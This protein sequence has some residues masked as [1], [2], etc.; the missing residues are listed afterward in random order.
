MDDAKS[1]LKYM[2]RALLLARRG[3]GR[4]A[5]NP[6]VGAVIVKN[7]RIIGEGW[8]RKIGGLHAE[9][10]A[11]NSCTESPQGAT[12]YVNLEPCHHYGKTPP[13]TAAVLKAGIKRVFCAN[14]DPN[15]VAAGGLDYLAC[16]G[17][18]CHHGLLEKEA[19][20]LNRIFFFRQQEKTRPFIALKLALSL[21][22]CL[23]RADGNSKWISSLAARRYVHYL[24]SG[25]QSILVGNDTILQDNPLLDCR[26]AANRPPPVRVGIDVNSRLPLDKNIFR[27]ENILYFSRQ[28]RAD[29]PEYIPSFIFQ[30]D[31]RLAQWQE[32]FAELR[33]RNIHSLFVEGGAKIAQFLS[34]QNWID[35]FYLFYGN[36]I[37]DKQAK[38]AFLNPEETKLNFL[39]VQHWRNSILIEAL[40]QKPQFK[41]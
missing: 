22:G 19:A 33:K 37:F 29:M 38:S 16:Q 25:Y 5:P 7:N 34:D 36:Y 26:L 8:H 12:I 40:P 31:N 9:P 30:T 39:R 10:E 28:K 18:E 27:D 35:Y 24:R 20:D 23:A 1:D 32:V 6:M 13:C 41:D 4:V 2:Q 11:I 14:K 17:I 3:F 15:P 21:N